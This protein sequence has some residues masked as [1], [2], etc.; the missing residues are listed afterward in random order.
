MN[1]KFNIGDRVVV[2]N[3]EELSEVEAFTGATGTV[4]TLGEWYNQGPMRVKLDTLGMG[5]F[6][7]PNELTRIEEES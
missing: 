6:F 3:P 2:S 5:V 7:Y 1:Q 4:V